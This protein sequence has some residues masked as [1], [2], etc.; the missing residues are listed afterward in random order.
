MTGQR[1]DFSSVRQ[2]YEIS[3]TVRPARSAIAQGRS[4]TR[5]S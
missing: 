1:F 2:R 3:M 4:A 5:T